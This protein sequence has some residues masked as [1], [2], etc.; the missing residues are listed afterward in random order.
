[1]EIF[2]ASKSYGVNL[3]TSAYDA[4]TNPDAITNN[5]TTLIEDSLTSHEPALGDSPAYTSIVLG[6]SDDALYNG[7]ITY[8]NSSIT[9]DN[10]SIS[11]YVVG[12]KSS[13]GRYEKN[14]ADTDDD[15]E[16]PSNA[17]YTNITTNGYYDIYGAYKYGQYNGGALSLYSE[18]E[19]LLF[20]LTK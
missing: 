10:S 11:Y 7:T 8:D 13:S 9:Y 3:K 20:L 4:E 2:Y 16:V 5:I 6:S 19:T 15:T 17:N 1:M 12:D 18:S 14:I